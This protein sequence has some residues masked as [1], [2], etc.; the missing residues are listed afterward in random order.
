MAT[1]SS[2]RADMSGAVHYAFIPKAQLAEVLTV[3]PILITKSAMTSLG[4][5][6]RA[7]RVLATLVWRLRM[8]VLMAVTTSVTVVVMVPILPPVHISDGKKLITLIL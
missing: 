1:A 3:L 2:A 4:Q 5:R 6:T 7:L 8:L